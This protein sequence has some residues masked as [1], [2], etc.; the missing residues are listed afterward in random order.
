LSRFKNGYIVTANLNKDVIDVHTGQ[1]GIHKKHKIAIVGQFLTVLSMVGEG[2]GLE[3]LV[4]PL[5]SV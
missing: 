1:S 4:R 5:C 2:A 3:A